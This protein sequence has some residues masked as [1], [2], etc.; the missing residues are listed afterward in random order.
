MKRI[1]ALQ[2]GGDKGPI[3]SAGIEF[4][5]RLRFDGRCFSK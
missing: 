1:V 2:T 4:V 5:D 3:T